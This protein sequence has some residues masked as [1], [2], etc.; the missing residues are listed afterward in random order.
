LRAAATFT[1]APDV[2][3]RTLGRGGEEVAA[4]VKVLIAHQAQVGFM[5]QGRCVQRL[6]R[7]LAGHLRRGEPAQS[8]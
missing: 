5:H 6:A 8:S 4:V 3:S 1:N 7:L 2:L